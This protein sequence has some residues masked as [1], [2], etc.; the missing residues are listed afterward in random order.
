MKIKFWKT[1]TSLLGI[2][3]EFFHVRGYD[4]GTIQRMTHGLENNKTKL[5]NIIIKI[6]SK[7]FYAL[8]YEHLKQMQK[9]VKQMRN[10]R[11]GK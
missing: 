3:K 11:R 7:M 2:Q 5:G 1:Q 6:P 4:H 10:K 9:E 8:N